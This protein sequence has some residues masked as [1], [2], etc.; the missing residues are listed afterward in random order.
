M[1]KCRKCTFG[2]KR[3][4][5][6]QQELDDMIIVSEKRK[7]HHCICYNNYIPFEIYYDGKECPKFLELK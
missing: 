7:R 3:Y 2:D 6:L 1:N 5:E 4:D